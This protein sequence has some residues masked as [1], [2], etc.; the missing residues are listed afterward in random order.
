VTS[1]VDGF[2][3]IL[4]DMKADYEWSRH[5]KIWRFSY[6]DTFFI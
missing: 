4:L 5:S 3:N 6:M 2:G 1:Y